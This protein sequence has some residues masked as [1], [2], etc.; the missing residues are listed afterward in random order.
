MTRARFFIAAAADGEQR[1]MSPAMMLF[2][3]ESF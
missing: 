1:V 3:V 2:V